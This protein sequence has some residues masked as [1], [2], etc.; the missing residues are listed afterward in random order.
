MSKNKTNNQLHQVRFGSEQLECLIQF[1]DREHLKITV[2]PDQRVIVKAPATKSLPQVLDK[3][4][5]RAAWILKQKNY[6]EQFMPRQPERTFTSGENFYYLGRQYRLKIVE[7]HPET[8]KLIGRF[9]RVHTEDKINAKQVKSLLDKWYRRHAKE[10]FERR[11]DICHESAKRYGIIRPTIK[12]KVMQR[13]WGSCNGSDYI[14]LN[15]QLVK[16]PLRCID[17][18]IIHELCHL[19]YSTHSSNFYR[20]LNRLLPDWQARK[21]RLEK[22][23]L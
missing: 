15:T 2:H 16:A 10:V 8:V 21:G 20:L 23:L 18:V 11:L 4:K 3:V 14:L 1:D 19:K 12:I 5:G 13:R 6:F 22:V 7:A 17:Y 9:F